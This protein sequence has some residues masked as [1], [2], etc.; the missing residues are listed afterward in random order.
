MSHKETVALLRK[1]GILRSA[2][3]CRRAFTLVETMIAVWIFGTA[4]LGAFGLLT[5]GLREIRNTKER[6]YVG[7]ILE[8]TLEQTRNLAWDELS[9]QPAEQTF[10]TGTALTPLYGK[11]I[12]S[13]ASTDPDFASP[14]KD[15]TGRI[16][17]STIN[18]VLKKIEVQVT[19]K[20]YMTKSRPQS[21]SSVTYISNTGIDRR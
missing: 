5:F 2:S 21:Y 6:I 10:D 4:M 19:F 15:A 1:G 14:L 16:F 11:Q 17:I 18:P 8:S 7:R 20:P 9:A 12:N 3:S 13:G